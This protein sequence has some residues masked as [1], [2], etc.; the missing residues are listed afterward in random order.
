LFSAPSMAEV[1]VEEGWATRVEL[2][3]V[4]YSSARVG[5]IA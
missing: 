5:R 3:A 4:I 1:I 2:D